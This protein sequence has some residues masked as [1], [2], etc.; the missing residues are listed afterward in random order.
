MRMSKALRKR[1]HWSG[2][3]RE[4]VLSVTATPSGARLVPALSLLGGAEVAQFPYLA[5]AVD[6]Q[7]VRVLAGKLQAGDLLLEV[8]GAPVAGLTSRDVTALIAASP[9]P[10]QLKLLKPG[11]ALTKDL[12]LYLNQRFQK[13]SVDH[14]LQ[15]TIRDNLYLRTVP[16]TTRPPREGE[17]PDVDYNFISAA[18]FSDLE[19]RGA[20]LETGTYEGN[21]YGT[22][23]PSAEAVLPLELLLPGARPSSEGKRRRN[24][25]VTDMERATGPGGGGRGAANDAAVNGNGACG[26]PDSSECDEVRV[27]SGS[28]S[29]L[30]RPPDGPSLYLGASDPSRGAPFLGAPSYWDDDEVLGPLP[31]RWEKASTEEGEVYF[32]DHDTKTTSWLDPRRARFQKPLEECQDDELPYGWEKIDDPQYGTY[33]VDH[34]NRKTQFENPVIEAKRRSNHPKEPSASTLPRARPSPVSPQAQRSRSTNDLAPATPATP[35]GKAFF[36]RDERELSGERVR[37]TLRKTSRGFGFTI[38]GGDQPEEFLQVKSLV[39]SGP[40]ALDGRMRTGDVIVSV[41]DACVLGYSQVDVVRIFQCIPIGQCVTLDLCRGYPLPFDP[42][43]PATHMVTAFAVSGKEPMIINGWPLADPGLPPTVAALPG[44]PSLHSTPD[45]GTAVHSQQQPWWTSAATQGARDAPENGHARDDGDSLASSGTSQPELLT[46]TVVKGPAGFGFTIA[47]GAGGQ[48]VR[49][50]LDRAR[51]RDLREGDLILQVGGRDVQ[52]LSHMQV[53]QMLKDCPV[54]SPVPFVVQRPG[55][56][57]HSPN[58]SQQSEFERRNSAGSFRESGH[59]A[60][61]PG[62]PSLYPPWTGTSP[63]G[64]TANA[65][66][67]ALLYPPPP[68]GPPSFGQQGRPPGPATSEGPRELSESATLEF[69]DIDVFLRRQETGFGFRILGGEEPGHPIRVGAVVPWGAADVDGRLRP[70]DELLSV[71]SSPVEGHVHQHVIA[72]MQKAAL[73]GHV[74][75]TVRRALAPAPSGPLGPPSLSNLHVY[76]GAAGAPVEPTGGSSPPEPPRGLAQEVQGLSLECTPSDVTVQRQEHEGFGFVIVSSLARPE[77]GPANALPHKIGRVV[78]GS[79]AERCGVLRVG[80]RI[81]AVNR[82]CILDM[83][84]A[85]IVMLVRD[86]G[87]T[88]TLAV[89]PAPESSGNPSPNTTSQPSTPG[90]ITSSSANIDIHRRQEIPVNKTPQRALYEAVLEKGERG[91]GFSIRGGREYGMELYVLRVVEGGPAATSS[92]MQVGDQIVEIGGE[93]TSDMT[94]ARAID[95]IRGSGGAVRLLLRHGSGHVPDH[96]ADGGVDGS[97]TTPPASSPRVPDVTGRPADIA[98]P[99]ALPV[100]TGHKPPA[101]ADVT[102]ARESDAEP[103]RADAIASPSRVALPPAEQRSGADA[104]YAERPDGREADAARS[105][106]HPGSPGGRSLLG[107]ASDAAAAEQTEETSRRQLPP[108]EADGAVSPTGVAGDEGDGSNNSGGNRDKPP[109]PPPRAGETMAAAADATVPVEVGG[110]KEEEVVAAAAAASPSR[111]A[112]DDSNAEPSSAPP[113]PAA[114]QPASNA[115]LPRKHVGR[116]GPWRVPASDR[117]PSAI[118]Q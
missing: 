16:C 118:K 108:P 68:Q 19:K 12:R 33:Y 48:R 61:R 115:T 99:S 77:G 94:H 105:D 75:L 60:A 103:N 29:L 87:L 17:V 85:D 28:H 88:V 54:G 11:G 55:T 3:L 84:H 66:R 32:I 37:T 67:R 43:D 53:V 58:R 74:S 40:A 102:S 117:I 9:S 97:A 93:S 49:H 65:P 2:R 57:N 50:I 101:E 73:N 63:P 15:Q 36:T 80:D 26:T 14:E 110:H 111:E 79:P 109:P 104:G 45:S 100:V 52:G 27:D 46:A 56:G 20:L 8:N 41:N 18:E 112:V 10:V 86:A 76:G 107:T 5:T 21:F 92:Q 7:Q 95:L 35:A 116:P 69:R 96:A 82:R 4:A 81:V 51:G 113:K 72:L 64:H 62:P 83:S 89:L 22:P 39:P 38:V 23:V 78:P 13:G 24:Q 6:E 98:A 114:V 42:D 91:F 59:P 31:D 25:S 44:L 70:G 106:F 47:D 30:Y 71:D 34:L 90:P 1:N